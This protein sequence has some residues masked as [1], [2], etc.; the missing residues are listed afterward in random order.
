MPTALDLKQERAQKVGEARKLVDDAEAQGR[1]LTG[2]EQQTYDRLDG[3]IDELTNRIHR[4]EKQDARESDLRVVD[5]PAPRHGGEDTREGGS[6]TFSGDPQRGRAAFR[7]WL[8]RGDRITADQQ[9]DLE[10]TT[11]TEG[12]FL[13]APEDFQREL[14]Q[15]V[16]DA[17]QIRQ[18]ATTLTVDNA[19]SIGVPSLDADPSDPEWTSELSTGSDDTAMALGKREMTPNPLA[20]RLKVSDK[21]LRQ[22]ALDVEGLV[23]ER[24]ARKFGV[25]EEK[26]FMTGSGSGQPLGIFT[27][28][29]QGISTSRDNQQ[30]ASTTQIEGDHL[31]NCKGD[32]KPQYQDRAM[33]LFHRDAI[34]DIRKRKDANNQYLWQPGLRAGEPDL[35]LGLRYVQSE[36]APN[37]FSSG[38][39]I[40]AIGDFSNYWIADAL[41]MRLQRLEELYA[42]SNQVGFIGRMELDGQPV[43]EEAFVR[44]Q[45]A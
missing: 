12:G 36:F 33:W 2:E 45:L 13:V 26:A 40:G 38:E 42:E 20:K 23:R 28:S 4:Q 18:M 19:Q 31:I 27:A 30:G 44:V 39:Y 37:T 43:L 25:A 9:R 14:I 29:S 11:D 7:S 34:T 22:S 15:A 10:A 16:D 17:V 1:D 35:I 24:L 6:T 21:L 41:S 8:A 3:E 32:L 5:D